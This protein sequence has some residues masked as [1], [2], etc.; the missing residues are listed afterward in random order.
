VP[1]GDTIFRTARTLHG[2][3]GGHPVTG[4]T[5]VFPA[6]NRIVEDQPIIG[7]TI[8]AVTSRGK[9]LL[10]AFS[11]GLTLHTHMRMNGSWHLYRPGERWQ[12]PRSDMR[13]LVSTDR[14][15]A[16]GFSVPIAEL[17][18]RRELAR[19]SQLRS[20]GPDPLQAGFDR[21]EV[22]KRI[23]DQSSDAIGD[24]LLDQRVVAGIGN[25]LKSEVLFVAGLN[26]FTPARS[27]DDAAVN[28]AIDALCELMAASVVD[29]ASAPPAAFGRRTT[30]SLDPAAR[31]WVYGRSGKPCRRCGTPVQ[32]RKTGAD[33]RISYWCPT[34]QPD[35]PA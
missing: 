13:I 6:V 3:L 11:G 26:P 29:S 24:V 12:R 8:E 14:I 10:M 2:A 32:S 25:V 5:S 34:C 19:H 21:G 15:V 22:I 4:F 31:L 28:R 1:E 16:V 30:R 27:L 17:L 18:S 9:H 33:A 23:R 7:Q 20:L 35:S